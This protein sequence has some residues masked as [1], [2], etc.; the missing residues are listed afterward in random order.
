MKSTLKMDEFKMR[1]QL[2]GI[3]VSGKSGDASP[4]KLAN[5]HIY[6]S[7]NDWEVVVWGWKCNTVKLST[8]IAQTYAYIQDY[9]L[10]QASKMIT[11][12]SDEDQGT[13]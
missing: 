11:E 2:E 13:V 1:L 12:S 4:K 6:I 9:S 7:G 5:N 8:A 3:G 10:K